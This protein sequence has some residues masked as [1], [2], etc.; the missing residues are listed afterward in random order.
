MNHSFFKYFWEEFELQHK[1]WS[2][3]KSLKREFLKLFCSLKVAWCLV[4]GPLS[5]LEICP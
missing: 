1:T 3:N 4:P 2:E 5:F